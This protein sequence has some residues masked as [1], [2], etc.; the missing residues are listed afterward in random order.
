[1]ANHT[2]LRLP[3][4]MTRVDFG[5]YVK[6]LREH[7]GLSQQ[8]VSERLHIRHRYI[9]AI[10][11]GALDQMPG[12]AYAKGYVHTYAEFLGLDA[13]QAVEICFGPEPVREQQKHFV[14]EPMKRGGAALSG[15]WRSYAVML[16]VAALVILAV[17]QL[18]ATGDGDVSETA[19]NP[20]VSEVPEDML[21]EM[22]DM[23]MPSVAQHDCLVRGR[24]LGCLTAGHAW[25]V[26]EGLLPAPAPMFWASS[27][28]RG[29]TAKDAPVVKEP[30]AEK[31]EAPK[32]EPAKA[33]AKKPEEKKPEPKK[34][35]EKK[36]EEKKPEPAEADAKKPA[37]DA[38]AKKP[39]AKED[40]GE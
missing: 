37:D 16:V 24:P 30:V 2:P 18:T 39:E 13:D 40:E 28:A 8:D 33:P 35:E 26:V 25:G 20:T 34:M 31:K 1:M 22:R 21:A 12:R 14:P 11:N 17:A 3:E 7:F 27:A 10:E 5:P 29:L 23:P 36:A 4:S 6:G 15:P 32:A 9:N 19:A 38:D